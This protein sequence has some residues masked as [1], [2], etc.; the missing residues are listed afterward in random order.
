MLCTGSLEANEKGN[1]SRGEDEYN[2]AEDEG[3][4]MDFINFTDEKC[5]I[6]WLD[7]LSIE[8]EWSA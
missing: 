3:F 4:F 1:W 8:P 7:V 5:N 6:E 2:L